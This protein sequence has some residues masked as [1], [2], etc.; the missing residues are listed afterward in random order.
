MAG[1]IKRFPKEFQY[2]SVDCG[3]A[4]LAM[5]ASYYGIETSRERISELCK[6]T[7][8]GVSLLTVR[9][10]ATQIGLSGTGLS[11]SLKS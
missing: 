7:L 3:S 10:A 9:E 2:D 4:C 1:H 11:L 6:T 8:N 5:I